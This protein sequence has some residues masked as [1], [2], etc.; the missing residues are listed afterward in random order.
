MEYVVFGAVIF[1]LAVFWIWRAR[2]GTGSGPERHVQG[3]PD[4]LRD[5]NT[6]ESSLPGGG[7]AW[8]GR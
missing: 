6:G 4:D 2:A 3:L 7:G 5:K 1:V 8:P